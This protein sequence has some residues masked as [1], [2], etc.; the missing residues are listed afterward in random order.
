MFGL[1]SLPVGTATLLEACLAKRVPRLIYTSTV[2]VV[3]GEEEIKE[4]NETLPV[5]DTFLFP[6]YPATKLRAEQLVLAANGAAFTT[7][8]R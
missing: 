8:K 5:P 2:D 4:G 7:G 1:L 3:I 6:G